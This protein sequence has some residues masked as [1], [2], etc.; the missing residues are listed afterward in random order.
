MKGGELILARGF[1]RQSG[2]F[3]EAKA[4]YRA[5]N[6]VQPTRFSIHM[7]WRRRKEPG[8]GDTTSSELI[9]MMTGRKVGI[10]LLVGRFGLGCFPK[11]VDLKLYTF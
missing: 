9:A 1:F 4:N 2:A 11:T 5:E 6:R 7:H 10:V 3:G 8:K